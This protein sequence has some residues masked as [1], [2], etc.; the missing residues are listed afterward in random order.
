MSMPRLAAALFF[1]HGCVAA[2]FDGPGFD[3]GVELEGPFL[4]AITHTRIAQGEQAAFAAHLDAIK[5]QQ[6]R[7]EGFIGRSL[8][9]RLTSRTRWTL[10][11]WQ[12]EDS[13]MRFVTSGAHLDAMV[14][15]SAVIDGVR[16][17]IWTVDDDDDF[18]P[19][20]TDAMDRL[21]SQSPD[22]PWE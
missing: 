17:A 11:I 9:I 8:R 2:P 12:D 15:S 5:D 10:T 1:L 22:I 4:A 19:K 6:D 14:E 13:M 21:D 20:W 16:S 3:D 18:P 7:H